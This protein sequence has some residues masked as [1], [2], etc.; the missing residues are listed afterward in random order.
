MAKAEPPTLGAVQ[1]LR[2]IAWD[3]FST[4]LALVIHWV[5]LWIEIA[6]AVHEWGALAFI[7]LAFAIVGFI[8]LQFAYGKYTGLSYLSTCPLNY[9]LACT[10]P[11]Q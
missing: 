3:I 5:R 7:C 8:N 9:L 4:Q 11:G 6:C 10:F 2:L 1:R